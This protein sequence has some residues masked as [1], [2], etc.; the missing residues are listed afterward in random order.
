MNWT[1]ENGKIKA[2]GKDQ[3][4]AEYLW[5]LETAGDDLF[6]TRKLIVDERRIPALKRLGF[7]SEKER[8]LAAVRGSIGQPERVQLAANRIPCV[9]EQYKAE[10]GKWLR[11]A[12]QA[13]IA[14]YLKV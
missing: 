1:V 2:D 5:T 7:G 13:K 3:D 8:E 14:D 11:S 9:P 4:F 10:V 12:G 6:A